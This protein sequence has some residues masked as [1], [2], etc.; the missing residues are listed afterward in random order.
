MHGMD[1][2]GINVNEDKGNVQLSLLKGE[3]QDYQI[4]KL[5]Y[6]QM[7]EWA[8]NKPKNIAVRTAGEIYTYQ[9]LNERANQ[10]AWHLRKLGVTRN[11]IVGIMTERSFDMIAGIFG[12]WKAGGAY[13]PIDVSYP[14]KRKQQILN[15]SG[16]QVVLS[17]QEEQMPEEVNLVLL[18]DPCFDREKKENP[19]T[20][21]SQSDLAYVIYTSGTTGVPKGVMLEHH[22][23]KNRIDWMQRAYPISERDVLIQKTTYSFDVSV[24]EIVWWATKGASVF[25]LQPKKESCVRMISKMIEKH[26]ISVIHFVPSVFQIFLDYIE[27]EFD[28]DRIKSLKYVFCSG[29]ALTHAQVERFTQIMKD[30]ETVLINL[31]GPTEAAI[32]V[33]H[34]ACPK[35]EIPVNIPIGKPIQNLYCY[36]MDENQNLVALGEEG[37]LYLGGAGLARGYLNNPELTSE[38]FV[39]NPFMAGE[40]IYRTGDIA[41]YT[42]DGLIFYHG[43][44]DEQVKLRGVRIELKEIEYYLSK[45]PGIRDCVVLVK[46]DAHGTQT[47]CAYVVLKEE[48]ES[49]NF[50]PVKEYLLERLPVYMLPASFIL[51][52]EIPL[53]VNGKADKNKLIEIY[54]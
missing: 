20:G 4:D 10:I 49:F 54:G 47:L 29:E 2:E 35:T 7:E 24:W 26:Q 30:R 28:I 15:D 32:D 17:A 51:A 42:E 52:R 18:S 13:L 33:T 5:V 50:E 21:S 44:S 22:A 12:I 14:L 19:P 25:M 41:S 8:A 34:F 48:Q 39:E 11:T 53:K 9:Q 45:Y 3:V 40:R 1:G 23:L 6:T 36:I 38:V 37:D 46:V 27:T 43:R 31:Y 16:V